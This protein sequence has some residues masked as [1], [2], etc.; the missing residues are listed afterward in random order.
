MGTTTSEKWIKVVQQQSGGIRALRHKIL[1]K[2]GV[3][4]KN[5]VAMFLSVCLDR[6]IQGPPTS[7]TLITTSNSISR[8]VVAWK[9]WP[10]KVFTLQSPHMS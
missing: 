5:G 3:I 7:T 2:R 4:G 1:S 9:Q 8:D 6:L 10:A